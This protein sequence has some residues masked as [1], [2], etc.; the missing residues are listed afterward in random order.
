MAAALH[1]NFTST[2]MAY[3]LQLA[4][5]MRNI[6]IGIVLCAAMATGC[7]AAKSAIGGVLSPK[8]PQVTVVNNV[9]ATQAPVAE[10]RPQ[11]RRSLMEKVGIVTTSTVV[12]AGLGALVGE[13][14]DSDT[15]GAAMLG[16]I[17]GAMAGVAIAKE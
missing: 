2:A 10:K 8:P 11:K 13:A 6:G 3:R 16:A 4:T 14:T 9:E 1:A 12:G 15:T 7:S 17:G 5:A